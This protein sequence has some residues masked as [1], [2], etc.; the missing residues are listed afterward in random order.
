MT[1]HTIE[2]HLARIRAD[3][4]RYRQTHP[5]DVTEIEAMAREVAKTKRCKV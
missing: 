2:A 4:E 5:Q 3:R 1:P